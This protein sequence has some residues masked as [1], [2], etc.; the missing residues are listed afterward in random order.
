VSQPAA[1]EGGRIVIDPTWNRFCCELM[2]LVRSRLRE[3]RRDGAEAEN[4]R[5]TLD[6]LFRR[7]AAVYFPSKQND[8][9]LW[10]V[11]VAYA[12]RKV[13]EAGLVLDKEPTPM[14]ADVLI[15]ETRRWLDALGR[16]ELRSVVLWKMEGDTNAEIAEKLGCGQYTV[17]RRLM[18][19]RMLLE[20]EITSA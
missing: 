4:L 16:E 7:V 13:R 18:R 11:L 1:E 17:E 3:A 2:Q 20:K 6:G 9:D 15:E 12:R 14:L 8:N 10:S 5:A 19:I